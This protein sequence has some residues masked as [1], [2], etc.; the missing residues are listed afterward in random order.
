MIPKAQLAPHGKITSPF[1]IFTRETH[2]AKI[3]CGHI[4][5]GK[6]TYIYPLI[7]D[8]S[9]LEGLGFLSLENTMSFCSRSFKSKFLFLSC[10]AIRSE[11]YAES[12]DEDEFW[13]ELLEREFAAQ[14]PVAELR[15]LSREAADPAGLASWEASKRRS[16]PI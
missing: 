1:H 14:T 16:L 11:S 7:G 5:D 2:N 9:V 10:L 15:E 13:L 3:L 8:C 4:Y 12:D 6:E